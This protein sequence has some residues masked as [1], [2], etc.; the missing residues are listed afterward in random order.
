[1]K[2]LI[3]SQLLLFAVVIAHAQTFEWGVSH[4][5]KTKNYYPT[6]LGQDESGIYVTS[7]KKGGSVVEKYNTKGMGQEYSYNVEPEKQKG[8]KK[9][10]IEKIAFLKDKFI[11]FT[12]YYDKERKQ[13]VI[14]GYVTDGKTGKKGKA[15]NFI[16][17]PVENKR[18]RGDFLVMASEDQTKFVIAHT[19]YYKEQRV[20]KT[21]Y[22]LYDYELKELA[23]KEDETEKGVDDFTVGDLLID[24]DGSIYFSKYYGYKKGYYIACYDANKNYEKWEEKV[25]V[26]GTGTSDYVTNLLFSIN[27]KNE[28]IVSGYYSTLENTK[29]V[30][31]VAVGNGVSASMMPF[32]LKG[33]FFIKFDNVS[34]EVLVNKSND[35]SKDFLDQFR[36]KRDIK[37]G[38]NRSVGDIFRRVRIT[39]K[40]DGGIVLSGESYFHYVYTNSRGETTGEY[41]LFSDVIVLNLTPEGE[42]TWANRIPKRQVFSYNR[43]GLLCYGSYGVSILF[44]PTRIMDYFSYT[45]GTSGDKVYVIFNDNAKNGEKSVKECESSKVK[46]CKSPKRSVATIYSMDLK[47]G[48]KSKTDAKFTDKMKEIYMPDTYYQKDQNSDIVIFS[49][50]GSKYRYGLLKK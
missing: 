46:K 2:K 18:R 26:E 30:K 11:V 32:R 29:L 45:V 36:T 40:D 43:M 49:K 48:T 17:T 39:N 19:A 20:Y 12:T 4:N 16:E 5:A 47:T 34:K 33:C 10:D 44:Y 1:M 42:L 35:F 13:S 7:W 22:K 8:Q 9:L 3:L 23:T 50:V 28:L 31:A 25:T 15:I 24:N 21:I 6:I 38:K 41:F 37:K 27:S 14:Q